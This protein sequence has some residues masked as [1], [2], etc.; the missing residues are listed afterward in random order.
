[1]GDD[2]IVVYGTLWCGDCFRAKRV[3]ERGEIEYQWINIDLNREA[4]K[5]VRQVNE[6]NL[7]VPTIVFPDGAI[8]RE[9]SNSQLEAKLE[10]GT[11]PQH[12]G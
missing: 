4:R 9:P 6:G 8:L 5:F 1:M 2:I 10:Q 7:V 3:F 11:K 12:G